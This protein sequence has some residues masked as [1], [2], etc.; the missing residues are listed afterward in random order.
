MSQEQWDP[1]FFERNPILSGISDIVS[2]RLSSQ[3][4]MSSW[5][6][7]EDLNQLW[8]KPV[9][10]PLGHE[11]RFVEQTTALE[12]DGLY[13]EQ[14]I[15]E[16]GVIP[17][18]ARNWHDLFNA[19]IWAQFPLSK[20]VINQQHRADIQS[21]GLSPRSKRRNA[22]TL[23]DE[24]GVILAYSDQDFPLL[25]KQHEWE[26]AFWQRRENWG[27]SILPL[28][29]GHAL[30]EM[31]LHP[32]LG[33]CGKALFVAVEPEFFTLS[34]DKQVNNLDKLLAQAL[35]QDNVLR[36]N[37]F[38]S[39]FPILG[40]PGYDDANCN[41]AYYHNRDYFRPKRAKPDI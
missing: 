24:C 25:L 14:R 5:L 21:F 32:F 39:P 40:V 12:Q 22:L 20:S 16:T 11:Y 13:Y 2:E 18:R 8:R 9:L 28:V 17:T 35:E 31:S 19:L 15:F 30:Y 6:T 27:R 1:R 4:D 26:Q 3:A 10:S 23:F 41:S 37:R 29:F 33:L 36:D 34:R 38:L 7:V